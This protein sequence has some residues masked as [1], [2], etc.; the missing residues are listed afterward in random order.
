MN[1]VNRVY[2]RI[3][4]CGVICL[5]L[6]PFTARA[7]AAVDDQTI[8]VDV[9]LVQLDVQ[10]LQK[11]TGR[12]VGSLTKDDF[13][14]YEDGVR[15]QIAQISRDQLPLSV[16]LLFDATWS[17]SPVLKTLAAGAL[18]AL[19]HLKPEDEVAVTIYG[20]AP[21]LLQDFT[22]DRQKI[23]AAIER[24]SNM[25][26]EQAKGEAAY[27]NQA[28]FEAS[29]QLRKAPD[30]RSRRTII[31]L[32]DNVPNVPGSK[33]HSEKEAFHEVF[34]TGTV[35][36]TLLE[37]SGLSDAMT[38]AYSKNP[39]FAPLRLKNPPGDVYKYASRTGGDV[40]KS[41]KEDVSNKLAQMIDEIRTRYTLGYYPSAMQ[42]KDKFCDIKVK[43]TPEADEREGQLVVRTKKGYYR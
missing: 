27:F 16:V 19:N 6:L 12:P 35:V 37:R 41:S 8:R 21:H 11:K 10:V 29:E 26:D 20:N 7:Q 40:M 31:W 28:V 9:K 14:V 15:Q 13:Q 33:Q 36:F 4:V 3:F 38:V 34:E 25:G 43:V 39:V 17:V 1:A 24:A 22:T 5:S 42:P 2:L 23:V 30:P 32:T 18:D